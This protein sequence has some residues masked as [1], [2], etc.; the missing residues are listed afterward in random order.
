MMMMM[1]Y[2]SLKT[3]SAIISRA[4]YRAARHSGRY[5]I[6]LHCSSFTKSVRK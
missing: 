6:G 3:H 5:Y 1:I 2:L 4:N